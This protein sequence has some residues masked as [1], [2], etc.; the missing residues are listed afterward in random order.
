[1]ANSHEAAGQ[2]V[3][4]ETADPV[5]ESTGRGVSVRIWRF[6]FW[7]AVTTIVEES[8]AED[9]G[10]TTDENEGTEDE[11][12]DASTGRFFMFGI[13]SDDQIVA[14]MGVHN[15]DV[16]ES[17]R[18]LLTGTRVESVDPSDAPSMEGETSN[19]EDPAE[20]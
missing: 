15:D 20:D 4:Q 2:N 11:E 19:P 14:K 10:T 12:T 5:S 1:M 3:Q 9:D 17:G 6:S 16:I 7:L 13:S 8:P 18:Y